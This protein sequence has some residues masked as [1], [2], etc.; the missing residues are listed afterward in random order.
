MGEALLVAARGPVEQEWVAALIRGG[1]E[2][3]DS[4]ENRIKM[5]QDIRRSDASEPEGDDID[6]AN[7]AREA[8]AM[9]ELNKA[10]ND[11]WGGQGDRQ[12][13]DP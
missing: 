6:W 4:V 8:A 2:E 5:S 1:P 10:A 12:P 13:R 11:A 9:V 7:V 3:A